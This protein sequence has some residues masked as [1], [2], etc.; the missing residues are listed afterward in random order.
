MEQ[1]RRNKGKHLDEKPRKLMWRRNQKNN[2]T[3]ANGQHPFSK[4]ESI[5]ESTTVLFKEWLRTVQE[6]IAR[7]Y[8]I[9]DYL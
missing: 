7:I 3:E 1:Q 9:S 5:D 2:G 8:L 6:Q 4:K